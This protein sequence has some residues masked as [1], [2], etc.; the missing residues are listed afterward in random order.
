MKKFTFKGVLDGFRQQVQPQMVKPEQEIPETLRP[1]HFQ[2]KK[3]FRH[4]F[5]HS[6]TALGYDPVQ[7][8]LAIGDKSGSLRI[9]GK[10]GVDCHVRHEGES[11][12]AVTH[13]QF[14]VNEGALIT[15][16]V[17]DAAFMEFSTKKPTSSTKFK[18][19]ERKNYMPLSA[20]C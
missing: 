16:T 14:L 7:K 3:T 8:L 17:D 6:P 2:L 13:I 11:A 9:L 5:P 1:E 12:C 18:I 20:C 10:P 15:V 19:S 4:G